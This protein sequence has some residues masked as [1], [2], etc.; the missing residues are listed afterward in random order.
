[1][2]PK[3]TLNIII[4]L[5]KRAGSILLQLPKRTHTEDV[6][7]NFK[8]STVDERWQQQRL[9]LVHQMK[10]GNAPEYF[11]SYTCEVRKTHTHN[12]RLSSSGSLAKLNSESIREC[13][14]TIVLNYGIDYPH[15]LE[16]LKIICS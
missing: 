2:L 13:L 16:T 11:N 3:L 14:S 15:K 12:T 10:H 4:K 8:W 9:C 1:M 6:L 7:S 5:H